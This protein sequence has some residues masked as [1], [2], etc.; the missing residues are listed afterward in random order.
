MMSC[1]RLG[2][3]QALVESALVLP[4]LIVLSLGILQVVL[5]AHA[6]DVLTSAV[7]EGA[8]L[9]AEDGRS[10]DEGYARA[11]AL[12]AAGL[13]ASVEPVRLDASWDDDSV[14]LRANT[15]LR[16]ILPLPLIQDLPIQADGRV[17]R[18]RFRPAG[19]GR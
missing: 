12:I 13:G 6:R 5:Y 11:Q 19:G 14:A 2:A 8:R 18:E 10:L 17:A 4:L 1:K 15:S 3:A 7:Q 9:A 16:P